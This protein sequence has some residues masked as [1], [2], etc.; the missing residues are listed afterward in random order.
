VIEN[1]LEAHRREYARRVW[2]TR[3]GNVLPVRWACNVRENCS[4]NCILTDHPACGSDQS[5]SSRLNRKPMI[6]LGTAGS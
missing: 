4:T 3:Y 5:G 6:S 1:F 2:R